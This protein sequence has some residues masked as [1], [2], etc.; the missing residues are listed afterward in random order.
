MHENDPRYSAPFT[1]DDLDPRET[2][3]TTPGDAPAELTG[4]GLPEVSGWDGSGPRMPDDTA[5][6]LPTTAD[7]PDL[8]GLL[9]LLGDV[10]DADAHTAAQVAEIHQMVTEIHGLIKTVTDKLPTVLAALEKSPLGKMF[11]GFS[12]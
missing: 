6:L 9:T 4:D 7:A 12:F 10:S 8:S 5:A 11:G 3:D 1:G 2:E